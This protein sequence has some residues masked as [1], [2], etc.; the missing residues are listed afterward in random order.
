MSGRLPADGPGQACH[1]SSQRDGLSPQQAMA[2]S[3]LNES[4]PRTEDDWRGTRTLHRFLTDEDV[5]SLF[6]AL[7]HNSQGPPVREDLRRLVDIAVCC[8]GCRKDEVEAYRVYRSRDHAKQDLGELTIRN[9]MSLVRGLVKLLDGL[10]LSLRHR[11][12]EAVFLYGKKTGDF[13]NIALTISS[14]T[15]T[16]SFKPLQAKVRR[17]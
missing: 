5:Y 2:F 8:V 14:T 10:Y 3:K 13:C 7:V 6:S 11:A 1:A 9:Y 4:I 16:G 15:S 17:I 12:F